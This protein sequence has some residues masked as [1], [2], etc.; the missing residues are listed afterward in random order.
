MKSF[1]KGNKKKK[2]NPSRVKYGMSHATRLVV[3][4]VI[5]DGRLLI[6]RH[7]E[8]IAESTTSKDDLICTQLPARLPWRPY[9][10]DVRAS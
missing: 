10:S 2:E 6:R 3:H 9:R 7:S 8:D 4:E 5:L 1:T